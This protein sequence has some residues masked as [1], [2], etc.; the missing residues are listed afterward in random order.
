MRGR[1]RQITGVL[2][3]AARDDRLPLRERG[4]VIEQ[5]TPDALDRDGDALLIHLVDDAHDALRQAL[6]QHIGVQLAG[7]LSDQADADA[8]LAPLGQHLLEDAGADRLAAMRREVVRLLD[9][10]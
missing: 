8:K 5:V 7:A 4:Q 3:A 9:Q 2:T 6:A 1:T 10:R